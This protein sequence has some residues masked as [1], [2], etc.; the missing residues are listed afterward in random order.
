MNIGKFLRASILK[1]IC[2]R[3][4]GDIFELDKGSVSYLELCQT[5]VMELLFENS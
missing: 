3:L 1:N 5:S 4:L 2:E